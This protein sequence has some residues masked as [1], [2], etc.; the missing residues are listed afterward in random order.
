MSDPVEALPSA[1]EQQSSGPTEVRRAPRGATRGGS[2]MA[3]PTPLAVIDGD[4]P[5][6]SV[7]MA[8][9]GIDKAGRPRMF[10]KTPVTPC[11]PRP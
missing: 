8:P 1:A 7:G 2:C 6:G 11:V 10:F 4:D 5:A 3:A 9:T